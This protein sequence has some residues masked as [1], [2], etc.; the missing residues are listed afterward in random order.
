MSDMQLYIMGAAGGV[1]MV[2]IMVMAM[3]Y[4]KKLMHKMIKKLYLLRNKYFFNGF[5][6]SIELTYIQSAMTVGVQFKL[7]FN[8]S[9]FMDIGSFRTALGLGLFLLCIPIW[10]AY[11]LYNNRQSL[12][13]RMT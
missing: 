6:K 1:V 7:Y 12:E 9:P 13:T 5:V 4:S 8:S 10:A 3:L 2:L 11:I